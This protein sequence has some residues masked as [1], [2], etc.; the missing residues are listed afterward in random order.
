MSTEEAATTLAWPDPAVVASCYDAAA[1]HDHSGALALPLPGVLQAASACWPGQPVPRAALLRAFRAVAGASD[2]GAATGVDRDNFVELLHHVRT[3]PT[4]P[5]PQ[6][7][8]IRDC[9][10]V[11]V[12]LEVLTELEG[13]SEAWRCAASADDY[14]L[15]LQQFAAVSAALGCDGN[16]SPG[17]HHTSLLE[18]CAAVFGAMPSHDGGLVLL[19]DL[20]TWLAPQR[21]QL[22]VTAR[23]RLRQPPAEPEGASAPSR[24]A[25]QTPAAKPQ[26]IPRRSPRREA[27]PPP[28]R[29]PWGSGTI[30]VRT[31]FETRFQSRRTPPRPGR[32]TEPGRRRRVRKPQT[33]PSRSYWYSLRAL[34]AL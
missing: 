27:S 11:V 5:T 30:P 17:V 24:P 15:T 25:A 31:A 19:D 10:Q 33:F 29:P 34:R 6:R 21:L 7:P 16:T 9:R 20:V 26:P 22:G 14:R 12:S 4:P 3:L 28:G 1:A 8:R 18:R 32:E 2:A 13:G 23:E